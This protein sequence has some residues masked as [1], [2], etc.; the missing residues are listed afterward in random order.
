MPAQTGCWAL[1]LLS[2]DSILAKQTHATPHLTLARLRT[3]DLIIPCTKDGLAAHRS[4]RLGHRR[5][6]AGVH[7]FTIRRLF[8]RL[9]GKSGVISTVFILLYFWH[10]IWA[11]LWSN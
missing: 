1:N 8:A 4:H 7:L 9:L 11:L 3:S 5:K 10:I 2:L 6:L